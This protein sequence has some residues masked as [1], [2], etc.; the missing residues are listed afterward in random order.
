VKSLSPSIGA[1]IRGFW[2]RDELRVLTLNLTLH[3]LVQIVALVFMPLPYYSRLSLHDGNTYYR[4]AQNLWPPQPVE[5]LTWYKRILHVL[6]GRFA[7]PW[8]PELSFLVVGILAAS[9]SAVY[10]FKIAKHYTEHPLQLT[11]IYSVLP[12]LFF[13]THHSLTEP[14]MMLTFLA[15]YYY[16]LQDRIAMTAVAFGLGI[17]AKELVFLPALAIGLL[18]LY[19]R[20]WRRALL[21]C[22]ALVPLAGFILLYGQRWGDLFWYFK[23]G[24]STEGFLSWRSGLYIMLDTLRHGTNSSANPT[25]A[26]LY[27]VGNQMLNVVLLISTAVGVYSLWRKGPRDLAC[28][29]TLILVPLWF[30]GEAQYNLNSSVGR[31]FLLVSLVILAYDRLLASR[32]HGLWRAAYWLTIAGMLALGILWTFLYA[33]FFTVYKFF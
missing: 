16:Y 12:W 30:L 20:G 11:L 18:I 23:L 15:G 28:L 2:G 14:L 29:N 9:F 4:I 21:F 7:V 31:K 3:T 19:R 25:V 17:L 33:R 8:N 24:S 13:A 27:D 5:Q 22:T 1:R 6:L 26:L 32:R 10:F